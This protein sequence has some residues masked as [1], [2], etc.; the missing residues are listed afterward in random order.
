MFWSH[1]A[2]ESASLSRIGFEPFS[3]DELCRRHPPRPLVCNRV[4]MDPVHHVAA[5]P[6]MVS[7]EGFLQAARGIELIGPL[8]RSERHIES[9]EVANLGL[10]EGLAFADSVIYAFAKRHNA[11]LWTQDARFKTSRIFTSKRSTQWP[12]KLGARLRCLEADFSVFTVN[13]ESV[14]RRR[15]VFG[16]R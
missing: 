7:T 1:S 9:M 12:K 15:G 2:N 10:K 6:G 13:R 11:L 14:L 5:L 8:G 3:V 16:V 4:V